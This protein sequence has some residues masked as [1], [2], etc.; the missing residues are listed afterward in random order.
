MQRAC[1]LLTE[2]TPVNEKVQILSTIRKYDHTVMFGG[3]FSFDNHA[4]GRVVTLAYPLGDNGKSEWFYM[5][6]FN[7]YRRIFMQ[8]LLKHAA[9]D[10]AIACA[11]ESPFQMHRIAYEAGEYFAAI[12][13]ASDPA[14]QVVI[15]IS[16]PPQGRWEVLDKEG[17]WLTDENLQVFPDGRIIYHSTV[18]ALQTLMFRC[19]K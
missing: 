12:N 19:I 16:R 11:E 17:N 13:S 10:M 18:P 3:V 5:G 2:F 6:F 8:K 1:R 15:S 9:P 4:G 14:D 7:P